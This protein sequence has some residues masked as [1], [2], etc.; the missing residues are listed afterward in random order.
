MVNEH[1]L[2]MRLKIVDI[3]QIVAKVFKEL[4]QPGIEEVQITDD[5][6]WEIPANARYD[7]LST[8]DIANLTIGQLSEDWEH[9]L[10]LLASDRESL[11]M[12]LTY[13]GNI[14]IA[15]GDRQRTA[16]ILD[17][18]AAKPSREEDNDD[19]DRTH[20]SRRVPRSD[21]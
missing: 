19:L 3:E 5:Y 2:A 18:E 6:Y 14:L 7:A 20:P 9:L 17:L 21:V 8:P 1:S 11:P 12:D 16:N 10:R 4:H 13:L 15:M